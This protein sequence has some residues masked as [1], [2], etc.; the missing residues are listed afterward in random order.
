L[1]SDEL[2]QA[3][4]KKM[5]WEPD[6]APRQLRRLPALLGGAL[7][8]LWEAAPRLIVLV[9][10]LQVISAV[11]T[12]VSLLVVRDVVSKVLEADKAH[13]GFGP[14]VPELALLALILGLTGLAFSMQNSIRMLLSDQ[15]EW[16]AFEKVLDVSCA[17]ELEAFD[18]SDFHDLLQRAQNAGGR[19]LMLTQGL[20]SLAGSATALIGLLVVLFVLNPLLVPALLVGV[21]PVVLV[22]SLFS[23]EFH[24]FNVR[25]THDQRRRFY[26]RSLL[27]GREMAKEVR[28]FGLIEHFR[29]LNRRLFEERMG[30]L[31]TLVRRGA[32]RSLVGSVGSAVSV[33]VTV[34]ILFW[35]ILSG[36]MSIGA[37]AAAAVAIVQ[38]GGMLTGAAFTVGQLY[39]SSL[40]LNDYQAFRELLPRV[41]RAKPTGAAPHG[42]DTISLEDV[43]FTYPDA[44]RPALEHISLRIKRG[45]VVALVGEN[46][47][48]KTTLAK[49]LCQLYRPQAGLVRWDGLDLAAVDP[50]ELRQSIAVVFQDFPQYLFSASTNIGLGRVEAL[51]DETR[52]E[53][54]ARQAGAH[55]FVERLPESYQT[56]LGKMFEGGADLSVGQWQRMALARAFF[57][58]APLIIL[59]EPTAALDARA[60]HDLFESIRGLFE[61]RTVLLISHRFS[62]VLSADRIFVLRDGHLVEQGTHAELM[63]E[64]GHYAELFTLQA[65]AYLSN[66]DP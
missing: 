44:V 28:A 20:L 32:G 41:Q 52:I 38:L 33:G 57:R 48:G 13:A 29:G 37:G 2:G 56:M 47:S 59:D 25:F 53:R 30:A 9:A 63:R 10:V 31:R 3:P 12:A 64:A 51:D 34:G 11:A 46:G 1:A 21:V 7:G 62:S 27:T 19:P 50:T 35:F 23:R 54:A 45:E 17:V 4:L 49:L 65:S 55:D 66:A 6:E 36:R 5:G 16:V 24:E 60:E 39:E 8:L 14:V 61:G 22:A 18:S 26:V 42:F 40:F 58:D 43:T 15:V